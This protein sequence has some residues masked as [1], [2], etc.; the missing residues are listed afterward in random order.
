MNLDSR[1]VFPGYVTNAEMAVLMA[2]SA[3]MVFPSLFEGFGLP[4][5]EAMAAGV[6]VACSNTTSLPEVTAGAAVLF[7]P[8]VPEQ[9][10][11]A[12]VSLTRDE[13]LRLRLIE[14]GRKRAAEF[15]DTR[16]MAGEYLDLF[17]Y[18]LK[19][20][21]QMDLISGIHAD[22]WAGA[23]L[24]VQVAP[25]AAPQTLEIEWEVPQWVPSAVLTLRAEHSG[26]A[27]GKPVELERGGNGVVSFPVEPSGGS[28]KISMSPVFV[29]A[30]A[31]H[32][33]D[34]REL[35]AMVRQCRVV[36]GDGE[37]VQLFPDEIKR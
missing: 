24:D 31:G 10:A 17:L 28:F 14:A 13:S 27:L 3:A 12:M 8:G 6:P 15:S 4:V 21:K 2:N 34:A 18:A 11:E 16:R 30:E 20:K 22:G 5:I 19:N 9:I 36:R 23:V 33:D 35:S 37:T 29:P 26:T 25:A 7:D 32:G 1:V